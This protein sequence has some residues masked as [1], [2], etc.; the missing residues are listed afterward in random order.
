MRKQLTQLLRTLF[1][2]AK[3]ISE[4]FQTFDCIKNTKMRMI[5]FNILFLTK[6]KKD[7]NKLFIPPSILSCLLL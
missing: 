7:K 5:I 3:I 1:R 2:V 6:Y 4:N